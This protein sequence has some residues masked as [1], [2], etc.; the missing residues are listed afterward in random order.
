MYYNLNKKR[1]K[2][3][4][5]LSPLRGSSK[6]VDFNKIDKQNTILIPNLFHNH[7]D[8]S[9]LLNDKTSPLSSIH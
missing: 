8:L 4:K 2:K 3:K 9:T 6:I 1:K 7:K 5:I